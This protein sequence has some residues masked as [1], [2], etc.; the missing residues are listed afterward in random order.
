VQWGLPVV[1][2]GEQK[3][4]GTL[5]KEKRVRGTAKRGRGDWDWESLGGRTGQEADAE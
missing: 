2:E 1:E 5:G 3:A 4:R